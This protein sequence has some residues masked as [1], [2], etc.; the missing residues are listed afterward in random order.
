MTLTLEQIAVIEAG[1]PL[2]DL[3]RCFDP[4]AIR[5]LCA[6]ARDGLAHAP[7]PS[8]P[9]LI[10]E[11]AI[12]L[13]EGPVKVVTEKWIADMKA[14]LAPFAEAAGYWGM[15]QRDMAAQGCPNFTPMI[16][17][18]PDG[19]LFELTTAHLDKAAEVMD[20]D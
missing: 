9:A 19:K 6:L 5:A 15:T 1:V 8:S 11:D 14:A 10:K 18:L 12:P 3:C 2:L 17:M 13:P 16:F 4:D 7:T 20:D